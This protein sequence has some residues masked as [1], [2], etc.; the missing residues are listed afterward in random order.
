M[1]VPTTDA[2][3][4]IVDVTTGTILGRE[5]RVVPFDVWEENAAAIEQM[6]DREVAR[7]AQRYGVPAHVRVA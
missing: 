7:F 3:C 6:S 4:V 5:I 2:D 1:F